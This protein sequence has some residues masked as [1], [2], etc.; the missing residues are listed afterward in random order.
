MHFTSN[1]K[2]IPTQHYFFILLYRIFS[3][4]TPTGRQVNN[5]TYLRTKSAYFYALKRSHFFIS[6]FDRLTVNAL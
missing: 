2:P 1:Q 5:T 3:T 6:K 4:Q